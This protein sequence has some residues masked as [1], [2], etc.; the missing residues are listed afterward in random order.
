MPVPRPARLQAE[1]G[2]AGDGALEPLLAAGGHV[3]VEED[4]DALVLLAGELAYLEVA[5]VCGGFPVHVAGAFEGLVGADA[6]EVA[7]EAAVVGFDLA[8]E[9][10]EQFVETGLGLD[11]GV[12]DDVAPQRDAHGLIE[13]A[14][15]EARGEGEAVL[16]EG[17]A[18]REAHLDGF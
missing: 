13:E 12:D 5:G 11:G 7:A 9:L 15:G 10:G 17:A 4:L 8:M 3:A 2:A 14:E 18:V 6:V 1:V 16:A